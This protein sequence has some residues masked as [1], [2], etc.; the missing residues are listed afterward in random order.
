MTREGACLPCVPPA[1]HKTTPAR[2]FQFT[3]TLTSPQLCCLPTSLIA[4]QPKIFQA[5]Q[6][7]AWP[8]APHSH[9]NKS[10]SQSSFLPHTTL[11]SSSTT[12]FLPQHSHSNST[13]VFISK[14]FPLSRCTASRFWLL[15][16]ALCSALS[17]PLSL[18]VSLPTPNK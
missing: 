17:L 9:I 14:A 10:V 3:F 7:L 11:R 15:P 1:T 16:W 2:A 18:S 8:L 4:R 13:Q 12:S 5:L 6:T